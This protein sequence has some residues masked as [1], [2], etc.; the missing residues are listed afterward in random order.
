MDRLTIKTVDDDI[1][2]EVK[3][4]PNGAYDILDLAKYIDEGDGEEANILLDI[5]KRLSQYEDSGLSPEEIETRIAWLTDQLTARLSGLDTDVMKIVEGV[6]IGRIQEMVEADKDGRIVVL[7]CKVGDTI[8][9]IKAVFSY[10]TKPMEDRIDFIKF[11]K[12]E[13]VYVCTSGAKFSIGAFGKTV[14]LTREEAEK[15]LGGENK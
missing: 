9:K 11:Y 3:K 2:Y 14:F 6:S 1:C 8:Y 4:D 15:A 5:S 13:I 7:P 12:D 10:F